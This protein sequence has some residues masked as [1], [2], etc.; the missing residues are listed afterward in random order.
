MSGFLGLFGAKRCSAKLDPRVPVAALGEHSTE[1]IIGDDDRRTV[2]D[3]EVAPWRPFVCL[4]ITYSNG[5]Q[6][7]GTGLLIAPDLVLTAAHNLYALDLKS[8]VKSVVAQVGVKSGVPAAEARGARVE[9]CPGYTSIRP[10]DKRQYQLDY[11]VV[12]LASHALHDWSRIAVDVLAQAP[13]GEEELKQSRLN[14]AG[15]PDE[16]PW[17][18]VL[19]TCDGPV[20]HDLLGPVTFGY[21]MDSLPGQSGGP[22][23]RYQ[24]ETGAF[25][26]AGVHVAGAEG[27]N[28]ARRYDAAMRAQVKAWKDQLS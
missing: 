17:P 25:A 23:F 24:S 11:G 7:I 1:A 27:A 2:K 5:D 15:Y 20:R 6:A 28:M 12:K 8:F 13:L 4:R 26:L 18:V 22:V 14:V 16:K 19:K 9:V 10:G 21:E 3:V